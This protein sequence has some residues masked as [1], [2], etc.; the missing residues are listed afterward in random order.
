M[1]VSLPAKWIQKNTLDKGDSVDVEEK[2]NAIYITLEPEKAKRHA[3]IDIAGLTETFIRTAIINAYRLGFDRIILNF[4]KKEALETIHH[5]VNERLIGFE[6]IERTDK[7]CV[8][9][10]ITEPSGEQFHNIFSKVWLNIDDLF[11]LAED[12]LKGK[13]VEGFE[14]IEEKIQ[15]FDNFCLRIISKNKVSDKAELEWSFHTKLIHAQKEIYFMLIH[16]S[17]TKKIMRNSKI[18]ALLARCRE[19]FNAVRKA[20]ETKSISIIEEVHNLEKEIIYKE[21]Y[22]LLNREG[23]NIIKHRLL[24]SA[25][26][27]YLASSPLLGILISSRPSE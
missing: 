16:L 21:G 27:F 18:E 15:Q 12:A 9:E 25:R 17:R 22:N 10:N 20:Y 1:M 23:D 19:L 13:K 3:T 24:A 26:Q 14:D 11:I 2:N 8:I 4:N 6:V 5:T 7:G